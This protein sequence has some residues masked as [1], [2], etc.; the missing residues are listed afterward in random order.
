MRERL[1]KCD[2]LVTAGIL[3][4]RKFHLDQLPTNVRGP[5]LRSIRR[6]TELAKS[7]PEDIDALLRQ[8]ARS[9]LVD[10]DPEA[11]ARASERKAKLAELEAIYPGSWRGRRKG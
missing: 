10:D 1:T 7:I 5:A 8:Y 4:L 9:D 11:Q 3:A 6:A 2:E